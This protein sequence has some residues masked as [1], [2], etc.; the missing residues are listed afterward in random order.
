M[1]NRQRNGIRRTALAVATLAALCTAVFGVRSYRTYLLLQSAYEV[2]MPQVSAVRAW[3]TL[4]YLALTYRVPEARLLSRLSLPPATPLDSSLRSLA[5][6]EGMSP[7]QYVQ[8]VQRS[9]AGIAGQSVPARAPAFQG[10]FDRLND[11]I[12]SSLLSYG[13]AVLGLTLLFGAIGFPLPTGI[14]A[15][16]AGSLAAAGRMDWAAAGAISIAASV[17][18]DVVTYGLGRG[19]SEQFLA[20]RGRWLGYTAERHAHARALFERWGGLTVLITRTLVSHLS[21]VVSLLA[22]ISHYRPAAFLSAALVGRLVWTAVYMGLGYNIGGNFEA[23]TGFLTNFSLLLLSVS[24]LA[25]SALIA[26][27]RIKFG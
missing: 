1:T 26:A 5:G 14:A 11:Q 18:G 19:A 20:R 13:Y 7:F 8:Q 6:R 27:G 24:V 3:M 4:R 9:I 17:L 10:L 23:A 25:G 22:G 12:L 2:G 21:S 15:T 16:V